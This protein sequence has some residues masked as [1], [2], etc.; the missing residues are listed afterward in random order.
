MFNRGFWDGYYLGRRLGEWSDKYGNLATEKKVYVGKAT[1][2]F[3]KLGVGEFAMETGSLEVGDRIVIMGPTTGVIE[4]KVSEIRVDLK[5]VN[6]TQKGEMFSMPVPQKV[7][8]SDKV[9]RI[10]NSALVND[11]Q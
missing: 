3:P 7:R 11:N 10:T 2:Y 9:Y 5:P 8:R 1:N 6:Q 4:M